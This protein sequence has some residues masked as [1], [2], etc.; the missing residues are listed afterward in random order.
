M[1]QPWQVRVT[2]V[3]CAGLLMLGGMR[4]A[5]ASPAVG[6]AHTPGQTANVCH[7]FVVVPTGVA[8]LSGIPAV[9]ERAPARALPDQEPAGHAM[10]EQGAPS[11]APSPQTAASSPPGMDSQHGQDIAPQQGMVCV[12]IGAQA[13]VAWAAVS[14]DPALV[15]RVASLSGVLT[16]RS[17]TNA[18][19]AVTLS[20]G[21]GRPI[22]Q[23]QV[24][25]RVR[26]PHHDQ[27]LPGAMARPMTPRSTGWSHTPTGRDGISSHTS[28][29]PWQACGWSRSRWTRTPGGPPPTLGRPSGRSPWC[30]EPSMGGQT[31]PAARETVGDRVLSVAR[32]LSAHTYFLTRWNRP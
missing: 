21:R 11:P 5:I 17:Q 2:S 24:R 4:G 32:H 10:G 16:A 1:P 14:A 27:H 8:V 9:P 19:L 31:L 29:S 20:R 25:L 28:T 6:A 30:R 18:A 12:A 13:A 15:V 23:A 22:V 7:G 26:M 3:L